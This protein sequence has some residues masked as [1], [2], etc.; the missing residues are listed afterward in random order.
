MNLSDTTSTF[1]LP[2][3]L[4]NGWTVGFWLFVEDQSVIGTNLLNV[5]L[6]DNMV[7]SVGLDTNISSICNIYVAQ[8]P[9]IATQTSITNL[10]ALVTSLG[11]NTV[12]TTATFGADNS[13]KWV[14]TRC[15]YSYDY[16]SMYSSVSHTA[17]PVP[18]VVS[19]DITFETRWKDVALDR[20]FRKYYWNTADLMQIKLT[21]MSTFS[22][23]KST[24]MKNL[25]VFKDMLPSTLNIQYL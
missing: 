21:G 13:N 14:Y 8:N 15:A 12:S 6:V 20:H 25:Y 23:G 22:T 18:V 9:S 1:T 16:G 17:S 4:T 11:V 3:V 2:R 24:F 10:K 5:V 19:K 7:I